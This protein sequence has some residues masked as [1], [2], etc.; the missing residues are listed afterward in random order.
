MQLLM[1]LLVKMLMVVV[2]GLVVVLG[3]GQAPPP[4]PRLKGLAET[5]HGLLS[6]LL[7]SSLN[8]IRPDCPEIACRVHRDGG[9]QAHQERTEIGAGCEVATLGCVG[10]S[11]QEVAES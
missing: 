1:V 9:E 6:P 11:L 2:Q 3:I 10:R 4:P 5:Q 7:F 8:F